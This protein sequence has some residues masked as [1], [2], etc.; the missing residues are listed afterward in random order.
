MIGGGIEAEDMSTKVLALYA[1]LEHKKV[2]YKKKKI[3]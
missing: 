3:P 1:F 2:K